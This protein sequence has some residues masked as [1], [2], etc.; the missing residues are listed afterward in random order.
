[1]RSIGR[2][3]KRIGRLP[4]K[5]DSRPGEKEVAHPSEETM[6]INEDPPMSGALQL[7]DEQKHIIEHV[8][9]RHARVLAVAGSGKT[10]TMA[11]RIIHLLE[12]RGVRKNQIQVLMFNRL[13]S[14]EFVDK[15][16]QLGLG[17]SQQPRVNTFHS[18]AYRVTSL[19]RNVMWFGDYEELA[20]LE[21]RKAISSVT[22]TLKLSEEE[23]DLEEAKRAISL[24]KG[25][26][27]PPCRA[28]YTGPNGQVYVSIYR[29]FEERRL[30]KNAITYEDFVPL[31]VSLIGRDDHTLLEHAGSL[32][33]IIVDEYQ[34]VNFGQECLIE[35]L[36]SQGADVMVVGDD[37]Q[38]IYEWRGA[39]SE[40]ILREF[41]STFDNKPHSDYS[42][43]SSFRFGYRMAQASYNAI[44]HNTNRNEKI[45]L[46]HDPKLDSQI[47]VFT[48]TS[49]NDK[50]V[51]PSEIKVLGRTFAQFNSFTTEL[52][53]KKVPFMVEG[54]APFISSGECQVLL[55]YIIVASRLDEVPNETLTKSFL[56]I[57]NKPSRYLGRADLRKMLQTG[58]NKK[59]S[60]RELLF[61]NTQDSTHN[62][63]ESQREKLEDFL[64]VLEE[65]A[66]KIRTSPRPSAGELLEWIDGEVKLQDHYRSY[67]GEGEAS[68]I[69]TENIGAFKR[70][71][72]H[73]G[74]GW[75]EF[76]AHVRNLDTTQGLEKDE[77]LGLTT[78]HR[79]KGLEFE[80]VVIPDCQE[81]FM[82]VFAESEDPTYDKENPKGEP[83]LAEWIENERRLFY[84]GMTRARMG[85][86]IGASDMPSEVQIQHGN[87][88]QPNRV[89]SRFLEECEI[90]PTLE[91]GKELVAAANCLEGHLLIEKCERYS[92]Y[93]KIV[94]VVKEKYSDHFCDETKRKLANVHLSRAERPFEYKR[95]YSNS[96]Q[97]KKSSKEQMSRKR[98]KWDHL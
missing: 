89:A 67:Y 16:D 64:F 33:Y 79:C 56:N 49:V 90:G 96:N 58:Q 88:A 94:G 1:M 38:T 30:H 92:A 10:T 81:G 63:R 3:L 43:T 87:R 70:Y 4:S 9:G 32:R 61:D 11:Y 60:L 85:L 39:R 31:A 22:K 41:K 47:T 84:V 46:A 14:E 18:Y 77:C 44:T 62:W 26:L 74:L 83:R 21:L 29:E 5:H 35:L 2:A 57:A 73:T 97:K 78:I 27:I 52:L 66:C 20:I 95:R 25:S 86:L 59:Q 7:T 40:Y 13:A 24:W 28:G 98:K 12:N 69:R 55:D 48:N 72:R 34:D 8:D 37:D 82:P 19:T 91:I 75:R 71:A 51:E 65:M 50:G 17:P 80:Y 15:L 68:L 36:A 53:L 42:L 6:E 45:L 23:V 93:H 76:V 54:R